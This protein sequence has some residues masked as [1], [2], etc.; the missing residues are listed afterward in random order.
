[1]GTEECTQILYCMYPEEW[2]TRP[3]LRMKK[4]RPREDYELFEECLYRSRAA[5]DGRAWP[6][7]E[8]MVPIRSKMQDL[9]N[10]HRPLLFFFVFSFLVVGSN[11]GPCTC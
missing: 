1:M 11:P 7:H 9:S 5:K 4:L 3:V 10:P 2:I 6:Q 8:V